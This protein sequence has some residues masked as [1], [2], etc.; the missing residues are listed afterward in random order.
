MRTV[1]IFIFIFSCYMILLFNLWNTQVRFGEEHRQKITKQSIRCIR[2]PGIRGSII[3]SDM[4]ILAG[5]S[6]QKDILF[7]LSEMRRP[8][9]LSQTISYI[10]AVAKEISSTIGR[11]PEID[12]EEIKRHIFYRPALPLKVFSNLSDSETARFCEMYPKIPGIELSVS[13]IRNYPMGDIA[14]HIIGHLGKEDPTKDEN[15]E[16]FF[17]YQI[18]YEGKTGIEKLCDDDMSQIFSVP[19]GGLKGTEG[20]SLVLVDNKGFVSETLERFVPPSQ[21]KNVM[22]TIN[23]KAQ[24]LA[25]FLLLGKKGAFVLMNS[26]TGEI[27]AIVSSPSFNPGIFIPYITGEEY[28]ELI[29]SPDKPMFNRATMAS[30]T[31]GSI[32]KPLIA[33]AILDKGI[34]PNETVNCPGYVFIG[35]KR[36]SCWLSSGHGEVNLPYAIEQSCNSYFITEGTKIGFNSIKSILEKAGIGQKTGFELPESTGLLPSE[37]YKKRIFKQKWN[38]FDTALLSIG[39]GI[40]LVTP[41]QAATYMAAISN[42]GRAYKPYVIKAAYDYHGNL[43]AEKTN[44]ELFLNID[45][46]ESYFKLIRDAMFNVVNSSSGTGKRAKSEKITI[47]GKTGTAEVIKTDSLKRKNTWMAGFAENKKNRFSFAL[48][49]EDGISGGT[50]CAPIIKEFFDKFID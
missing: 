30:Y 33:L 8:G 47:Y 1:L 2:E 25:E 24:E 15:R 5:L 26:N 35:N 14:S 40:I 48:I 38:I 44:N 45:L 29:N 34:S 22:L 36:I 7:H 6:Q 13:Y 31:P 49:I 20:Y 28:S 41:I 42:N 37:E 46:P 21:G 18:G 11:V 27:I 32:L 3:S 9:K 43:I 12:E 17:Y 16:Q 19:V 4:K 10:N 39:Q 23:S 50:T